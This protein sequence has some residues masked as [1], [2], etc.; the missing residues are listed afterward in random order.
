MPAVTRRRPTARDLP[1]AVVVLGLLLLAVRAFWLTAIVP[2]QDYPQFLVFVRAARDCGDPSSPFHGTYAIA[3]WYVPTVLPIQLTR[4]LAVLCGG[5]IEAAGKLLLTLDCAALVA[6]GAYLLRVLGRPRWA[7]VLL[8][9][10]LHSRWTVIGG[11]VA[12]ATAFPIIVLGWA[13]VVRW[14]QRRDR[15]CGV[16]L[17]A[18]LCVALLWHGVGF[19]MLGF[20]FAGLWL[21]WRAPSIRDRF[22]S[23][24]PAVPSLALMA[25]WVGSTFQSKHGASSLHFRPLWEAADKLLD[26]VWAT[27]PHATA[28]ALLLA[29]L[30]AGGL[31]AS[32]RN[33]GGSGPAS[34][35]WR[36]DNPFL[37]LSGLYLLGFFFFPFDA[38]G[39]E[40]LSPRFSIQAAMAFVFAWNLPAPSPSRAAVV[41][42][43][44]VFS[45]WCLDDVADRFRAFDAETRG[46]SVLIDRVGLHE[47]LY[48][49]PAAGGA[50]PAFNLPNRA[51][52]EL[53]Q[54]STVRHGGLPNSSFAGY[55][56]NYVRYVDGN[57]M[58]FLTGPPAFGP[59]MTRFD[60]VLTRAGQGPTDAHFARLGDSE[61]WELYGVCGS[62]RFATCPPK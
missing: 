10:I 1:Y 21:L 26:H 18:C 60:Y 45:V 3:P 14:L 6:A 25:V 40:V 36:V 15:A 48:H 12:Y 42:A 57:P 59:A 47:T 55:G 27:V 7:I 16:S 11:Y 46:A 34:R 32:R 43:V 23:V 37:F 61:G 39:V 44:S 41:A 53:Q 8:F 4:V 17:A 2:G 24:V 52:I 9:P 22:L 58:P 33:V 51:M 20:G 38:L 56:V 29:A 49:W 19:A 28:R 35:M 31:V 13:L 5:S 54:F 50:S 62:K 30:V